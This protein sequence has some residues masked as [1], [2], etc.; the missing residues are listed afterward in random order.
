MS[1]TPTQGVQRCECGMHFKLVKHDPLDR[2]IKPMY[3]RGYGSGMSSYY[4]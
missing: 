3:G 1:A 4:S 2:S